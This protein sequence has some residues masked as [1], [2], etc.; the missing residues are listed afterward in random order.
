[1]KGSEGMP[2]AL[3]NI[4]KESLRPPAL[5]EVCRKAVQGLRPGQ[6]KGAEALSA[7]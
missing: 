2:R 4:L 7:A 5:G 1:M 6:G 3:T